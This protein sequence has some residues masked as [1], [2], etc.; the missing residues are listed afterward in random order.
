MKEKA[1]KHTKSWR[2]KMRVCGISSMTLSHCT[3]SVTE[4]QLWAEVSK[5]MDSPHPP[6]IPNQSLLFLLEGQVTTSS[7]TLQKLSSRQEYDQ[8]ILSS[9]SQGRIAENG[10]S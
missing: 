3:I 8:K 5:K 6:S 1:A 10:V 9:Q 2:K 7:L 4:T